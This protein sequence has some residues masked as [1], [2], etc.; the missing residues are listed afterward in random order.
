[1]HTINLNFNFDLILG[2]NNKELGAVE[3]SRP[4]RA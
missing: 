3:F 1:M 4:L 2:L